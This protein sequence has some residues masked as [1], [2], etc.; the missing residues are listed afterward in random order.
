VSRVRLNI[1]DLQGRL[2]AELVNG[3]R[4]AGY[5]DVTFEAGN[6][7]SG[8]YVYRLQTDNFTAVKKMLLVK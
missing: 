6:L 2:V 4:Q 1:Y 3:M 5:H 7:S 8:L